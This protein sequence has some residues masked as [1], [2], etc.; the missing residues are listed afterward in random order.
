MDTF[1]KIEGKGGKC[2][3]HAKCIQGTKD[4]TVN[5]VN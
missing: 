2:D 1:V 4:S 3:T 5:P